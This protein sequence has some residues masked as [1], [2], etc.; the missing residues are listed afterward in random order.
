MISKLWTEPRFVLHW[1]ALIIVGAVTFGINVGERASSSG[2]TIIA[3]AVS[4]RV[5]DG[6][7]H[8]DRLSVELTCGDVR[9]ETGNSNYLA[10]ILS[11]HLTS[12]TCDLYQDQSVSGCVP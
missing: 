3:S 5:G 10:A 1:L 8:S 7:V 9:T 6:V 4:C 2:N 12:L 11:K